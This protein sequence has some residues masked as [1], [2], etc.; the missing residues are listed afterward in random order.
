MSIFASIKRHC[1]EAKEVS[2]TTLVI[3]D[4]M[5]NM[6]QLV[7]NCSVYPASKSLLTIRHCSLSIS[8]NIDEQQVHPAPQSLLTLR[9]SQDSSTPSHLYFLELSNLLEEFHHLL[10]LTVFSQQ[11]PYVTLD[12]VFLSVVPTL[13][14][15]LQAMFHCQSLVSES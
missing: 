10:H 5:T 15:V 8:C 3:Q 9:C 11:C 14:A 2:G 13:G 7:S 4:E 6:L 1:E 12:I